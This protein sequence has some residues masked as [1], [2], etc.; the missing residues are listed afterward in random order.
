MMVC[1]VHWALQLVASPVLE[2][3][4]RKSVLGP[5]PKPP[6]ATGSTA[7]AGASSHLSDSCPVCSQTSLSIVVAGCVVLVSSLR[8]PE[9]ELPAMV[10]LWLL[11]SLL[12]SV[13]ISVL[14]FP[15]IVRFLAAQVGHSL[16]RS[17]RSRRE[18]LLAR[19][20]TEA[21]KYEVEA[22]ETDNHDWDE[23]AA[24][25]TG[26]KEGSSKADEQWEGIVG[27]FHPFW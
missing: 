10:L 16:R 5:Q 24:V 19:V 21:K 3:L 2:S 27:F 7:P 20:A 18:L 13:L 11:S 12:I 22:P 26:G 6:P 25:A 23:I 15:S 14:F 4:P 9:P 8:L 1:C 17:S